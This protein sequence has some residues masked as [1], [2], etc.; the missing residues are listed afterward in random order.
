LTTRFLEDFARLVNNNEGNFSLK[1]IIYTDDGD[2]YKLEAT[3]NIFPS[4][5]LLEL[6]ENNRLDFHLRLFEDEKSG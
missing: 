4:S 2:N 1:T 6:L 3:K 5:A